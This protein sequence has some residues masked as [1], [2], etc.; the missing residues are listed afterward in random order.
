M[1]SHLPVSV[2]SFTIPFLLLYPFNY[3]ASGA[4]ITFP[5][6]TFLTSNQSN[7]LAKDLSTIGSLGTSPYHCTDNPTWNSP[8]WNPSDC[9]VALLRL[10]L[11]ESDRHGDHDFEF[12]GLG[13]ASSHRMP[14]MDT[15][16]RYTSGKLE[17]R[18][19]T[20]DAPGYHSD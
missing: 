20:Y 16:R 3:I 15:P 18:C 12:L 9:Q 13:A 19:G 6:T 4:A 17:R 14:T 11:S 10:A 7:T 8:A 1:K 5:T 2:Y